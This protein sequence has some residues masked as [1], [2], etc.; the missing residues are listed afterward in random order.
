VPTDPR[1]NHLAV[2]T[3][4]HPMDY[5]GFAGDIPLGEYGGG[6]V[7]IWDRGRYLTEKWTGREVKVVLAGQRVSGRYVLIHTGGKNWLMHRMDRPAQADFVSMP[8]LIQPMLATPGP[9]PRPVE[10]AEWAYETDWNGVRTVCY[11]DGGRVRLLSGDDRDITAGH[12]QLRA[13]GEAMGSV[14]AIL[15]GELVAGELVGGKPAVYLIS[16]LLYLNGRSTV[17]LAYQDRRELLDELELSGA[18]W[19]V[20]RYYRG[21]GAELLRAGQDHGIAGILGKRLGS[22]YRPGHRSADWRRIAAVAVQEVVI[23]GWRP[24]TGQFADGIGSLLVATGGPD[25]WQYAGRAGTGFSKQERIELRRRLAATAR[26]TAPLDIPLSSAEA[27]DVRYLS[28][29]LV[30]EVTHLGWTA[31]QRL[32]GASWRG[33][34]PDRSP[35]DVVRDN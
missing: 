30:G 33:L 35:A 5:A 6:T 12:P 3:E 21:A 15:D 25:G 2:Q 27:T 1:R 16:D 20:P 19:Q 31:G 24:G 18:S 29:R 4:D 32:R 7:A 9:L 14:Q 17:N 28:P 23:V 26:K 13:L 34:R 11:V 10:D 22:R 8:E